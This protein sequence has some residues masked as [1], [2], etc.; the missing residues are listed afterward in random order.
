MDTSSRARAYIVQKITEKHAA[1]RMYASWGWRVIPVNPND[2]RPAIS[3]WVNQ[4]SPDLSQIDAWWAE[5]DYNIGILAGQASGVDVIDVDVK[6]GAKGEEVMNDISREIGA[7]PVIPSQCTPSGGTHYIFAHNPEITSKFHIR[8][9]IDVLSNGSY[10]LVAPSDN[11]D[12]AY[13]WDGEFDP[14]DPEIAPSLAHT[15]IPPSWLAKLRELAGASKPSA[16]QP[17]SG[18]IPSGSR[19]NELTSIAGKLRR[20]GCSEAEI[21]GALS[22][23]NQTRCDPPV[24]ED[25]V[26]RIAW[27]IA[28]N[29]PDAELT[30]AGDGLEHFFGPQK[31]SSE[32][33]I[34]S[35][36]ELLRT[37][38]APSWLIRGYLPERSLSMIYGPSGVGKTFIA[39]DM[40]CRL[41]LQQ[42]WFGQPVKAGAADVVYLAGEGHVGVVNR[43]YGWERAHGVLGGPIG[44]RLHVSRR[45]IPW[46][47]EDGEFDLLQAELNEIDD[48]SMIIVDTLH[49]HMDGEENSSTDAREFLKKCKILQRRHDATILIVHHAAAAQKGV[50]MKAR[51]STSLV[52][53]MDC[54]MTVEGT[55]VESVTVGWEKVKDAARPKPQSASLDSIPLGIKDEF[56]EDVSTLYVS[57]SGAI[58]KAPFDKR[59]EEDKALFLQAWLDGGRGR[60]PEGAPQ[61]SKNALR[62][63]LLAQGQQKGTVSKWVNGDKYPSGLTGRLKAASLIRYNDGFWEVPIDGGYNLDFDLSSLGCG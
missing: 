35:Y 13:Y 6:N 42:D 57:H 33:V 8:G 38:T 20:I 56:G 28:R 60:S 10:F 43:L 40:A 34:A 41:V 49:N 19:N 53:A 44:E 1:A 24:S 22:A 61:I 50:P 52:A 31:G 4:A 26:R 17:V 51:G 11:A 27:S 59:L 54:V 46:T 21:Y 16:A 14:T 23:S 32:A 18:K 55:D 3:D 39:L 12:G 15:P 62:E 25:E 47:D 45:L 30:Y 63:A 36:G 7:L 5:A 29:E 48:L 58:E 9:A 2:K 37:A